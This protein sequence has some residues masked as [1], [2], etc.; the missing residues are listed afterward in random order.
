MFRAVA[1]LRGEGGGWA[2]W[3]RIIWY[4][5]KASI[6]HLLQ[7][8]PKMRFSACFLFQNTLAAQTI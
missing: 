6:Y 1:D 7:K 3:L 5:F 8:K 2:R 4:C